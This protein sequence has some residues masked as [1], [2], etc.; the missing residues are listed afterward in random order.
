MKQDFK[1]QRGFGLIEVMAVLIIGGIAA[2]I[3]LSYQAKANATQETQ[4]A[5]ASVQ[6]AMGKVHQFVGSGGT[7]F[8]LTGTMVNQLSPVMSPLKFDNTNIRDPNGN[9]MNWVGNATGAA[10]TYVVTYG[11]ATKAISSESCAQFAS[12][13]LQGA[14]VI[15]IGGTTTPVVT[16]GGLATSGKAY[17]TAAGVIDATALAAGCAE[18]NPVIAIQMH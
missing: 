9:I 15:V 17:K 12:G 2:A 6:T 1:K 5:L 16:T 13:M 7:Y 18:P 10:A 4:N 14:D 8:G 11:G 3:V